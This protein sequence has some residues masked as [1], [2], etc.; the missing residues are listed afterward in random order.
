VTDKETSAPARL[1]AI[2]ASEFA[3]R[4]AHGVRDKQQSF[5][6]FLGAGCSFTSGI[7]TA[8]GLVDKWLREL[9]K[10]QKPKAKD[11]DFKDWAQQNHS[12]YDLKSP[13]KYY[14]E[15]LEARHP[16]PAERQREIEMICAGTRPKYGYAT[17][18]ELVSHE[19]YGRYCNT[20]LTTNFD[21]LV[22]DALYLFGDPNARPLVVTHE[23]LARFVRTGS[24]RPTVVKLHGDAHLVPK[25]LQIETRALD[26]LVSKQLY[27]FL[28]DH[29]LI[30]V[31]YGGNDK[32]IRKL[33]DDCPLPPLESPI[34]WVSKNEPPPLFAEL[35]NKRSALR[36]DHTDFDQLLHLIRG[37]LDIKLLDK[38]RWE[39][40]GADYFRDFTRLTKEIEETTAVSDDARALRSAT[41]AAE[42]SLP[43]DWSYATT[44]SKSEKTDPS[45]ADKTYQDGLRKF[46]NSTLLHAMYGNFLRWIRRDMDRAGDYYK[47][48]IEIEPNSGPH[49]GNYALF[50]DEIRKDAGAEPY[51]KRA[52]K[53]NPHEASNLG[54]Y[55]NFL[56]NVLNEI[57]TAETYYKRALDADPNHPNNLG[58]YAQ[59]LLGLGRQIEGLAMLDRATNA[60]AKGPDALHI[61]LM[62]YRY[63]HNS[64]SR[65]R[66]LAELKK[67]FAAGFRTPDWSF[68]VTL[69]RA[70]QD[71][72]PDLPLLEDLMNV[73]NDSAK[74][75]VLDKHAA[76]RAA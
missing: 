20:I 27:P 62:I 69:D 53:A 47:R 2:S 11:E 32:S 8:G 41:A 63:A 67:A 9:H 10:F 65:D 17:L 16:S 60:V 52:L 51:F 68:A 4:F 26:D 19:K 54:N 46:P 43:D 73:A 33:L 28:Q 34:Y 6:W 37:A 1:R 49:L 18:A 13:A 25:N 55:A 61:E 64:T 66:V 14:A 15:A 48:A 56:R 42:K 39:R 29:A 38:T 57:D 58:N 21:D 59:F 5:T 71:G 74:I 75:E 23:A 30:F 45:L 40:I 24:P 50:L 12:N 76:W 70:R 31:G 22:A 44:A 36:V 3:Q 7:G 72:H 35:L